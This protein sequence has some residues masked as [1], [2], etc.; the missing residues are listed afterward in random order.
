M[1][2]NILGVAR[3][4]MHSKEYNHSRPSYLSHRIPVGA[5][6]CTH[7]HAHYKQ[8]IVCFKLYVTTVL[9][10]T[11]IISIPLGLCKTAAV[12]TEHFP[13]NALISLMNV[14]VIITGYV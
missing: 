8:W 4:L 2:D 11:E 10:S 9:Y 5:P 13:I 14:L 1:E 7:L 6:F 3:L 12:D